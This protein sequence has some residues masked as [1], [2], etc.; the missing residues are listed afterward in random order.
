MQERS[1][2]RALQLAG[3]VAAI[4]VAAGTLMSGKDVLQMLPHIGM[5]L[6]IVVLATLAGWAAMPPEEGGASAG[7]A[8]QKEETQ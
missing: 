5:A 2:V 3:Y 8:Q 7:K 6:A 4:M 1:T